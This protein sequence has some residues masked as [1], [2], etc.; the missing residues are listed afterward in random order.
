METDIELK[1]Q[2]LI[3]EETAPKP[4]RTSKKKQQPA[5]EQTAT[6]QKTPTTETEQQ[7]VD[8]PEQTTSE[9]ENPNWNWYNQL[10]NIQTKSSNGGSN[11]TASV[12]RNA[13]KRARKARTQKASRRINRK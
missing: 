8:A 3:Q 9:Q 2:A 1:E 7:S 13:Q 10:Q 4:K 12:R 6:E 5:P 11:H